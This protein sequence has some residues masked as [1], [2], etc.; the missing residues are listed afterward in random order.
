M[1]ESK[2]LRQSIIFIG[3]SITDCGR[4]YPTKSEYGFGFAAKCI[5]RLK[6]M[7]AALPLFNRGIA[8][9]CI[10]QVHAR[11]QQDCLELSPAL[12]SILIG[13]NDVDYSYRKENHPF[14][15]EELKRQ[16]EEMYA[17]V[18]KAGA[19]LVV[20]EPHAFDGELY[21]DSFFPRLKWLKETTKALADQ[22]ADL[23]IPSP[24]TA[25]LTLDGLHPTDEGHELLAKC[26]MESVTEK[27]LWDFIRK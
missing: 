12:V 24:M 3:D 21:K 6:E 23:Y 8:G 9:Q 19:K 20:M 13:V 16:L 25:A 18:K 22:Y 7:D 15:E 10:G 26:W 17:S 2:V 11:W 27:G 14:V 5:H 1:N 4:T